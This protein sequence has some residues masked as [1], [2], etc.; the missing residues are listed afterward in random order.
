MDGELVIRWSAAARLCVRVR[1]C[2]CIVPLS[3]NATPPPQNTKQAAW[4]R[5]VSLCVASGIA[6]PAFSASL[7]YFDAY[8]RARLPANLTQVGRYVERI[9]LL[10]QH[11]VY[12]THMHTY[13]CKK[14]GA[15]FEPNGTPDFL[16]PT[17]PF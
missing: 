17:H 1:E 10:A 5:I 2:V 3:I 11:S 14:D 6:C 12:I 15:R 4:R 13:G 9:G 7:G 8:R 16:P